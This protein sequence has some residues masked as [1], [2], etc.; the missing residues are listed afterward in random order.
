MTD[1]ELVELAERL[2]WDVVRHRVLRLRPTRGLHEVAGI[3]LRTG[4]VKPTWLLTGD[5]MLAVIA[6][7]RERG[8]R[9]AAAERAEVYAEFVREDERGTFQGKVSLPE[10]VAR[11]ALAALKGQAE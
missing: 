6:A 7:M 4:E 8:F 1:E 2:G 5:G 10:A 3:W 11:A 9:W